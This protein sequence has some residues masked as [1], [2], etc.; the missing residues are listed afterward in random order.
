MRAAKKMLN[1]RIWRCSER[2]A[3]KMNT[4]RKKGKPGGWNNKGM[5]GLTGR[6]RFPPLASSAGKDTL[7]ASPLLPTW[8]EVGFTRRCAWRGLRA[9]S[10]KPVPV[11]SKHGL[12]AKNTAIGQTERFCAVSRAAVKLC[13]L[14]EVTHVQS[15]E[16]ACLAGKCV[17][18]FY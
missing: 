7:G 3:P 10:E 14:S 11:S 17:F 5:R 12:N 9:S 2:S 1:R 15:Q 18:L 8:P 16:I 6:P 4:K 13:A